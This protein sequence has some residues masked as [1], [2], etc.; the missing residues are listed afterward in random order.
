LKIRITL[1]LCFIFFI[2]FGC[3]KKMPLPVVE[4]SP[5]SFGAN[6]TSYTHLNLIWDAAAIGYFPENPM[7]PVDIA[8]GEDGYLFA[9]DSA[10]DRVITISP[11]GNLVTHQNLNTI[12]SI[13]TPKGIDIDSKLN[14]L[15]VNGTNVI[16]VWNQ[17]L[18]NIGV[19]SIVTGISNGQNLIF[20][21][22]PFKIDSVLGI[23]Q[24]YV[25]EN[26]ASSFQ[27][28][29]FGPSRD[30]T[31]F[32]TDKGN[33]RILKLKIK[34]SGAVKL[35]NGRIHPSFCG[36]YE[37]N[38]ASYG[39][40]AGTV[41]NPQGITVDENGNIYFTQLGGNFLVQKLKKQ[42][43]KYI[44]QYTLYEDPIMDLNRFKGPYDIALDKND[45]I[46]V[47]DTETGKAYKFFN[48]GNRAGQIAS[49]GRKGLSEKTFNF[50]FSIAIS[51]NDIVYIADT[52]NHSI[53]RFQF[54]VSEEDL[55]VEQPK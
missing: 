16:Y 55:P 5:E 20:S 29:A 43:L 32:I 1:F 38:I 25:D 23:H 45:N 8:I 39:S 42:G 53:E 2:G 41:D 18:N 36:V 54:S 6:D 51:D 3:G 40:G 37:K 15:I 9:A 31:I 35:K 12:T 44:S 11:S 52:G 33:N 4:S 22:D 27:G 34:F 50:P 13:T 24:F 7:A 47:I 48:K 30:S 10:N 26:E 46:F 21:A 19:D 28:I 14:L 17:Y 49:L